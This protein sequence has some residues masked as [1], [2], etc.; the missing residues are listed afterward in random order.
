MSEHLPRALNALRRWWMRE[1]VRSRA[2]AQLLW[3]AGLLVLSLPAAHAGVGLCQE[4]PEAAPSVQQLHLRVSAAVREVL[5][6]YPEYRVAL[7]SRD[8]TNLSRWGIRYTHA[9]VALRDH[10]Q[11]AWV[12]RQLYYDCDEGAPR[13]FDQGMAG[14]LHGSRHSQAGF[15]SVTLVAPQAAQA[16]Q[17]AALNDRVAVSL[18]HDLYSA[19]AHAFST[20]YQNCNQWVAELMARAWGGAG[21]RVQAQDWLLAAGYQAHTVEVGWRGWLWMA[22][23]SRW[24]HL[25]DHPAPDVAAGRL[26]ISLPEG[27]QRWVVQLQPQSVTLQL[28]WK[29]Q[30]VVWREGQDPMDEHCRPQAGDHVMA[31]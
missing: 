30:R 21:T 1:F 12:V 29:D 4:P 14:F 16:L 18:V 17:E 8:G 6:A 19:N 25:D 24:L 20:R 13:V 7:V 2:R 26:R 22:P 23:L 5:A 27:L 28:C 10:P 3:A 9:G 31:P 15:L 11:G